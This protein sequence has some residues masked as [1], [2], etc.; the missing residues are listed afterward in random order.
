MTLRK[1]HDPESGTCKSEDKTSNPRSSA[2][3]RV[4]YLRRAM[5]IPKSNDSART[6]SVETTLLSLSPAQFGPSRKIV[7]IT[8]KVE[9]TF[10]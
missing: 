6:V 7:T 1:S 8:Q 3:N 10:V 2:S 9:A 5:S 4:V